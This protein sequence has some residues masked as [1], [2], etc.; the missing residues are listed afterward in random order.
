M[1]IVSICPSNTELL[2]ALGLFD[3]VVGVDDYSDWPAEKVKDLPKLG[4][5]LNINME[6]LQELQPDLV[7]ASLSVPGMEKNVDRLQELNI[8]YLVLNPKTIDDIY[9]DIRTL[10]AACGVPERA[11]QLVAELQSKVERIQEKARSIKQAAPKLYWEWWPRPIFTPANANWLTPISDLAGGINLFG[12]KPGDSYTAE[13]EEV[14][15]RAPDYMF[16]VWCGVHADKVKTTMITE[17]EGYTAIPA[18]QNGRVY[19]L[20]EGLY[21]RPS[22]RLFQGL[23]ELVDL[24]DPERS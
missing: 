6:R 9:G 12:D 16:A 2:D 13:H 19:V 3:Q 1:R 5:D 7:I 20:E 10:G 21:C 8:P 4:P 24:L 18:V 23:E 22:Q 14:I 15:E 17:R 11:Q